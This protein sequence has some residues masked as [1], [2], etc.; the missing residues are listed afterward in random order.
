M[1]PN[2]SKDR[3]FDLER[4]RESE[5]EQITSQLHRTTLARREK[6]QITSH[7]D[8]RETYSLLSK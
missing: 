7:Q 5:I 3:P 4:V 1:A 8:Y 6:G 2:L